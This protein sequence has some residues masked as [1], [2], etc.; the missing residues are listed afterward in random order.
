MIDPKTAA[1][2]NNEIASNGKI[3]PENKTF[4]ISAG[5]PIFSADGAISLNPVGALKNASNI[6]MMSAADIAIA[7]AVRGLNFS[8][9][10]SSL[11]S[12]AGPS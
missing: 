8:C 9:K 12:F 4:P 3:Y 11:P 2:N 1:S 7:K 6:C 10:A 5:E